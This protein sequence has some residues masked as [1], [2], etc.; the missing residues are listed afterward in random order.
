MLKSRKFWTKW[1][2]LVTLPAVPIRLLFP[3]HVTSPAVGPQPM[4]HWKMV[5]GRC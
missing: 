5:W 1:D 4:I 2:M 3:C